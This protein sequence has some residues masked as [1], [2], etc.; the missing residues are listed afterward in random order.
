[1]NEYLPAGTGGIQQ[2]MQMGEEQIQNTHVDDNIVDIQTHPMP[3][4][5]EQNKIESK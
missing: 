5:Q 1:M 3:E 4:D 2:H